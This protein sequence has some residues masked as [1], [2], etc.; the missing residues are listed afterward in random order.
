MF[1]KG[2]VLSGAFDS[3]GGSRSQNFAA[4]EEALSFGSKLQSAKD[5]QEG[6]LFC[7]DHAAIEIYE[8]ALPNVLEWDSKERLS[9]ERQ[10]LGFYLS[11]HPLRKYSSEY[12][13]FANVY[14]GEPETYKLNEVVRACGVIA[15][16]RT[17]IDKSRQADGH[18]LNWMISADRATALF[19]LKHIKISNR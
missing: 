5:S 4:I 11:D 7:D 10:V 19:S 6:G 8:P 13:S 12:Y 17:R 9:K 3:I 18:S 16:I 15:D 1:L 14:L 2:L